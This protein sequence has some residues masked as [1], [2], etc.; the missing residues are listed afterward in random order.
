MS[1]DDE[2]YW[3]A[4]RKT[5]AQPMSENLKRLVDESRQLPPPDFVKPRIAE[6]VRPACACGVAANVSHFCS[7]LDH[8]W[9]GMPNP[10][11][12]APPE[13]TLKLVDTET[14]ELLKVMVGNG[15]MLT[16][17]RSKG[18][19]APKS[20]VLADAIQAFSEVINASEPVVKAAPPERS[21]PQDA[22]DLE[23]IKARAAA[24]TKAP[25]REGTFNVW[26]DEIL[27]CIAKTYRRLSSEIA[28]DSHEQQQADAK[29]IAHARQ[30]IPALIAEIERLRLAL[31][32]PVG[33]G[34]QDA[35]CLIHDQP[36]ADCPTCC[37]EQEAETRRDYIKRRFRVCSRDTLMEVIC[38]LVLATEPASFQRGAA[39]DETEKP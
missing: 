21:G 24:A 9:I 35:E 30:D 17:E 28:N 22:L 15:W 34:P 14:G 7:R 37:A 25:W 12:P 11:A 31:V 32:P 10:P 23:P 5:V 29:F 18:Y 39:A 38:D 4:N 27:C 1:I 19:S 26:M 8:A 13:R 20:N 16:L 36:M 2:I 3:D 33:P 6:N